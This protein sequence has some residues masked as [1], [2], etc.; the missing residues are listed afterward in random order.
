MYIKRSPLGQGNLTFKK[1][2]SRRYPLL[3]IILYVA[4]L[5]A[6]VLAVMNAD[7][8]QPRVSALIGPAPT[9]TPL[10]EDVAKQAEVAY[11]AGDLLKASQIYQQAAEIAPQ[12]ITILTRYG[13]ILTLNQQ[14]TEATA[15]GDR[16]IAL[17]PDDPRGYAV[18]A[19]ALDWQGQYQDSVIAALKAIELDNNYAPAHAYLAEGYADLG[20][21]RQ[22]REQA[23]LAIQLDPYD[24]DGRRNYGYVLEF[25]GDYEGAIQQYQQARQLEPNL[26]ELWYGLA[27][28]YRGAKQME[29]AIGT[30]N[31]IAIRTPNDPSI[32]VELGKT[33]FEM[34]EDDAAQE[35]LEQAVSLVCKD[36]PAYDFT[37]MLDDTGDPAGAG[38]FTFLSKQRSLPAQIDMSAWSRLGE[39]YFTR[40]NYESAIN[41][42][43]EAIACA[44]QS[45]CGQAPRALPIES[46]YVT[47]SAYFYLDKCAPADDHAKKAL[48][49]YVND[50]LDDPNAL[51]SI[52]CV[53]KLC[54]DVADHPVPY[55][56]AGFTNGFPDGYGEPDCVITRGAAGGGNAAAT[57][58]STP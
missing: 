36:C 49:K 26:L 2:R 35:N 4:I 6:A 43:E 27:R 58:V 46:Y 37:S 18:K 40:R 41:I 19:R 48:D 56:G 57:P 33:Y 55:Q 22:A 9:A 21:L 20:R 44:E 39:V 34:R 42:L 28:N 51:Q 25:Y 50:K 23:E 24:V 1:R 10:P 5:A 14:L 52:L 7:V 32:Y 8:L 15:V 30:F 17:A 47:A 11:H 3:L 12:D 31:Q 13:R 38:I 54:R 45:K 53:F 29:Q 16:I